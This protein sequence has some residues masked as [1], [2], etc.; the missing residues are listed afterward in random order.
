[1]LLMALEGDQFSFFSIEV[2]VGDGV[3]RVSV[4]FAALT[5]H[6]DSNPTNRNLWSGAEA[7]LG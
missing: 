3:L 7:G 5:A 6:R 1:M 4:F 2:I